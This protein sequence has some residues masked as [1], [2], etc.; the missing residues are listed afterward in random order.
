MNAGSGNRNSGLSAVEIVAALSALSDEL[1]RADTKGEIC[2]FGGT[3]MVLVFKARLSTKDVDAVFQPSQIIRQAAE[4]VRENRG[5]DENW[6]NDAVK[7]FLA[8]APPLTSEGLPQF[9]NLQVTMPT[10]EY[11]LAMKCMAG[12]TGAEGANDIPVVFLTR[13]LNLKSAREVLDIVAH[14]YG[15]SGVPVKTQ[16]LVEGLFEEGKI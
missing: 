1:G 16:Y 8:S 7:G 2:L 12:R 5:L 14:Y 3:V 15:K 11:L 4:R 6:L 10:A 13:Q 9:P